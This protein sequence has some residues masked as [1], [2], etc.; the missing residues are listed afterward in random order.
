MRILILLLLTGCSPF[1]EYE[2]LSQPDVSNDGY[3]L[4][5]LGISTQKNS[6]TAD[7]AACENVSPNRGTF[8]KVNIRY[9]WR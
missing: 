5:C 8:A 4:A 7:I 3:D 9:T 6:F 2:H 1:V